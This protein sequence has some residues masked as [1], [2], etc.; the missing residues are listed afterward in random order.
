MI[1]VRVVADVA[2][3]LVRQQ[4][5]HLLLTLTLVVCAWAAEQAADASGRPRGYKVFVL[6]AL[7][8]YASLW[9]AVEAWQR[10]PARGKGPAARAARAV[11]PDASDISKGVA[12]D[13]A[14]ILTGSRLQVACQTVVVLA[15][16]RLLSIALDGPV[17]P[18]TRTTV[19]LLV[20][21][22][23]CLMTVGASLMVR[24][25]RDD[26]PDAFSAGLL[27]VALPILAV[28]AVALA[29]LVRWA[30][31]ASGPSVPSVPELLPVRAY[32]LT[33]LVLAAALLITGLLRLP[34]GAR[35]RA[36]GVGAA[37]AVPGLVAFGVYRVID[38]GFIGATL[39][40]L[41]AHPWLTVA[42]ALAV[43]GVVSL[44]L[45]ANAGSDL[46]G[47]VA[48]AAGLALAA[49]I[50]A[51]LLVL[52]YVLATT[53]MWTVW[54]AVAA[55]LLLAGLLAGLLAE[56]LERPDIDW[57]PRLFFSLGLLAAGTELA[58]ALAPLLFA[59][60]LG[61]YWI[62]WALLGAALTAGGAVVLYRHQQDP[63]PYPETPWAGLG[64]LGTGAAGL[65]AE[66]I[67]KLLS[68]G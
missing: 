19:R 23:A 29:A 59:A 35:A 41:G 20:A 13:L 10:R 32:A 46:P 5:Q 61:H 56:T 67:A 47:P 24:G 8:C 62:T 31:G 14:N 65:L 7:L 36:A 22:L 54:A 17:S 6:L 43:T 26:D 28:T 39:R 27:A 25:V 64:L 55:A 4:I 58:A 52:A 12:K 48:T 11:A 34:A 50:A 57:N 30:T 18:G 63:Y 60:A 51:R 44:A 42:A 45:A 9:L 40:A 53:N 38:A 49:E 68:T 33:A 2:R 15:L 21:V 3:T 1:V 16:Y 66:G 37:C